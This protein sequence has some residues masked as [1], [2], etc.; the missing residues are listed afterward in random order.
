MATGTPTQRPTPVRRDIRVGVAAMLVPPVAWALSLGLSYAVQDF[1]CSAAA[2]ASDPDPAASLRAVL[3]ALNGV[4]LVA[5]LVAGAGGLAAG[6]RSR[7]GKDSGLVAF[8]GYV[9]AGL[10]L[11]FAFG[12]VLIAANPLVLEVCG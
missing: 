9:G 5:T 6:R 10:A 3:L 7:R 12:I 1:T 2:S 4:L 8:L 11:V